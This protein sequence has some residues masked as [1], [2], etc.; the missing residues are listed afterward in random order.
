MPLYCTV[1][2]LDF[3]CCIREPDKK[4][5]SRRSLRKSVIRNQQHK[6]IPTSRQTAK[7]RRAHTYRTPL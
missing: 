2:E 1:L 7:D 5:L 4:T 6:A 3:F